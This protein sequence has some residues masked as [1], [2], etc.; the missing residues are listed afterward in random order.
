MELS[1]SN[2]FLSLFLPEQSEFKTEEILEEF[3]I[4][5][6]KLMNITIDSLIQEQINNDFENSE[7]KKK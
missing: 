4:Y 1:V 7:L 2:D 6:F 3:K 5:I